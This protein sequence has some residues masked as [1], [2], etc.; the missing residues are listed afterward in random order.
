M[1]ELDR[2][3]L[4]VSRRA[5]PAKND[6]R[7]QLGIRVTSPPAP[8]W[9]TPPTSPASG[10]SEPWPTPAD[11]AT[12]NPPHSRTS[13]TA[14][15]T[16]PGHAPLTRA[17]TA[18]LPTRSDW[19]YGFPEF[20]RDNRLPIPLINPTVN[21]YEV[22]AYFPD[23]GL[24]VELDSWAYHQD[25]DNCDT[26]RDR[27][28]HQLAHGLPTVRITWERMTETRAQEAARLRQILARLG[29]V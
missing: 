26:D 17:I 28:A 12:S 5:G 9:T 8:S 18:Y 10:C 15:P 2:R 22:D 24:I 19:E 16:H 23:H 27:D 1:D 6:V 25:R 13:W 3:I 11:Q 21:G 29:P 20:C 4:Q 14:N 7:T